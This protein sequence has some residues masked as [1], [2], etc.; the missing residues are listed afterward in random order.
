[1]QVSLT[2]GIQDQF[3]DWMMAQAVKR[4][5]RALIENKDK[6]LCVHS[7]SGH[8]YDSGGGAER[9]RALCL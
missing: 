6:F 2:R 3:Y 8:K 7:S 9:Q 4:E 5:L 1:M